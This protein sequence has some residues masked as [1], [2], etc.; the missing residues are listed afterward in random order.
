MKPE[1]VPAPDQPDGQGMTGVPVIV[2][3]PADNVAVCRC[4]VRAG[5]VLAMDGDN[6]IAQSDMA[7]GH[8]VARRFIPRGAD[9]I[10]YGM[11]IGSA[12]AD[13]RPGEWV[14]LHNLASNYIST[15]TRDAGARS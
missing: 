13:V 15:H 6:A 7:I 4:N 1:R 10:K 11:S 8:K 2:L 14:H 12:T 5:T 3:S 9:V